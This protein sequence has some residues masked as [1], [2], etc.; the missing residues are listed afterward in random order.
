[1]SSK[2]HVEKVNRANSYVGTA[3]GLQPQQPQPQQQQPP[4]PPPPP[5]PSRPFGL[6][7]TVADYQFIEAEV[8]A[9]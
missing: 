7:L 1:M 6:G 4:P 9:Q 3:P 8:Y 2:G 5:P